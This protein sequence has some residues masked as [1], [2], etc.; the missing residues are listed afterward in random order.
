MAAVPRRR[1]DLTGEVLGSDSLA[2][3]VVCVALAGDDMPFVVDKRLGSLFKDFASGIG[4]GDVAGGL[5]GDGRRSLLVKMSDS[6]NPEV[7][8]EGV[9]VAVEFAVLVADGGDEA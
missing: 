3:E 8:D 6:A 7:G 1:R 5:A 9:V 2:L 4:D